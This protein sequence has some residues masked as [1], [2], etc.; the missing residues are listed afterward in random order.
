MYT[1]V[2]ARMDSTLKKEAET[3]LEQVGLSHSTAINALYSQIVLQ[4]GLPFEVRIP[5]QTQN[6]GLSLTRIKEVVSGVAREYGVEKVWL[7]GSYARGEADKE[8]DV[9]LRIE[10]GRLRGLQMGGFL[11]DIE[12]QLEVSVD[13]VT[14]AS[15]SEDMRRNM[16]KEEIMIYERKD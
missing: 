8:S 16:S 6:T 11:Y 9:D 5:H 1:T 13:V 4:Q 15:V 12:K 2:S 3:V 10:K 7:F 14:E